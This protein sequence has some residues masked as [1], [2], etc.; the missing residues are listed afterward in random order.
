M[1]AGHAMQTSLNTDVSIARI[2]TTQAPTTTQT[3]AEPAPRPAEPDTFE[4]TQPKAYNAK[5][6]ETFAMT[7]AAT[8]AELKFKL[9]AHQLE[10][11]PDK[12]MDRI[13]R[14]VDRYLDQTDAEPAM[15]EAVAAAVDGFAT[16]IDAW[17]AGEPVVIDAE[18][19]T[20]EQ[21][22]V[23]GEVA[24]TPPAIDATPQNLAPAGD[25]PLTEPTADPDT[26]PTTEPGDAQATTV[27]IRGIFSGFM[28]AFRAALTPAPTEPAAIE[29]P[30]PVAP[31]G[32]YT[33]DE[34]GPEDAYLF[35]RLDVTI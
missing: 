17:N 31:V 14:R 4:S 16:Q 35:Q 15:R 8:G 25:E 2:P 5:R 20:A 18:A 26:D 1:N 10:R 32:P 9:K 6:G 33:A 34:A 3:T 29:Q 19:E 21:A 7:D 11:H 13:E 30:E 24:E 22:P 27:D 12:V 23:D 28:D